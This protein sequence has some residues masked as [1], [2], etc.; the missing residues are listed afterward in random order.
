MGW[1]DESVVARVAVWVVEASCCD[2]G[3]FAA[4]AA[5]DGGAE[6]AGMR[7]GARVWRAVEGPSWRSK[8]GAG[9]A[10]RWGTRMHDVRLPRVHLRGKVWRV[11]HRLFVMTLWMTYHQM[12][13]TSTRKGDCR[14]A[15]RSIAVT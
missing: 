2:G 1:L 14:G 4:D 13:H 3:R 9:V 8:G 12:Y 15:A 7:G 10:V 11:E 5:V 6:G